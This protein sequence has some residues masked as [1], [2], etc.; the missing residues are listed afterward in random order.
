ML[1]LDGLIKI[2]LKLPNTNECIPRID[3]SYYNVEGIDKH[4]EETKDKFRKR[5]FISNGD[6]HSGQCVNFSF[7]PIMINVIEKFKDC[8]FYYTSPTSRD[9]HLF[10]RAPHLQNLFSTQEIIGINVCD[11]NENSYLSTKCDVI[12]GRAS[13]PQ[14]FAGVY[15]NFMDENKIIYSIT[16]N[17]YEGIWFTEGKHQYEWTDAGNQEGLE[18]RIKNKIIGFCEN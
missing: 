13:G 10:F 8:A 4:I 5:I 14:A 3:Y 12:I 1:M 15:D 9:H 2:K 18:D 17:K 7:D 6:V 11:L 16:S